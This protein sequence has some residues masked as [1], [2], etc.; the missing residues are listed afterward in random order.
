[1]IGR[2]DKIVKLVMAAVG[3]LTLVIA[4]VVGML[5]DGNYWAPMLIVIAYL[6]GLL[7]VFQIVKLRNS[8]KLRMS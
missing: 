1:M 2:R 5:G 6:L 4:V 7:I 8:Y 3:F